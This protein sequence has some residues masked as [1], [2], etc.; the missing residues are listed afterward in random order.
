MT[1]DTRENI[2]G[3]FFRLGA[4]NPTRTEFTMSEIAEKAGISRQAIYQKHFNSFQEIIDY[5]HDLL[6]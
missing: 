2:I 4:E 6:D 3:A 5:I 1:R